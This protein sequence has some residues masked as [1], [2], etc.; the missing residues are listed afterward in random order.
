VLHQGDDLR[1]TH[2]AYEAELAAIGRDMPV[3]ITEAGHLDTGDDEEIARF[4]EQAFRDWMAD[5]KVVA[6]TPLFW[7][8]DRDDYWM[9]EM[10]SKGVFLHKS[11][12]YELLRRIPKVTGSASFA[13]DLPNVARLTPFE[14]PVTAEAPDS[15]ASDERASRYR[16]SGR[17]GDDWATAASGAENAAASPP[18]G[19]APR[20]ATQARS[21][22]ASD[23]STAQQHAPT[24]STQST[25]RADTRSA[26][27][28][29]ALRVANTDGQGARLRAEPS[30]EANSITIV[31]DGTLVQALGPVLAGDQQD[32][33]RVR[34]ED[35]AEG[36][37]A[38]DLLAPTGSRDQ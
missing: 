20:R 24:F 21:G 18:T 38:V 9:F 17:P 34:T 13:P 12:T 5:P 6:A 10:D 33:R 31:P 32:W 15:D 11:P 23:G 30:H 16:P 4:Y 1:Y 8:P 22:S 3:L 29:S 37:I 25:T 28:G 35:G 26:G 14:P 27:G 36:W 2:L 7:H 19:P